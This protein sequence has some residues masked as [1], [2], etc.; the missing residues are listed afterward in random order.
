MLIWK[1][2][3][4]LLAILAFA[5]LNPNQLRA[6]QSNSLMDVS[7]DGKR[8]AVANTDSGTVTVF[9]VQSRKPI[10]EIPVGT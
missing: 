10:A 7:L 3:P 5:L 1:M 6:G 4:L 9:D 2:N 8:I